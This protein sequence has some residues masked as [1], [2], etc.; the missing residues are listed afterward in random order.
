VTSPRHYGP[1]QLAAFLGLQQ[2]QVERAV[3]AGA[4]PPPDRPRGRWSAVLAGAARARLDE[5]R[6]TAGSVPDLGAVRAAEVLSLR[7]GTVVTADG[8][9]ELG[10][11]GRLP[12]TGDYKGYPLYDGR[13]LESFTDVAAAADATW[14]GHLR[15]ADESASYLRVRRTD[16][17]HLVRAGLL[18]PASYGYGPYDRKG[19]PSVSLYRTG[20]L[21]SL[22]DPGIDWEAVRST[23]AGRRSPLAK[24]PSARRRP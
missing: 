8:V 14:A 21:D 7:L 12:V 16:L 24:L 11:R 22:A 20:D 5:V 1:V 13:E 2:W 9:A 19:R 18:R 3:A 10:R 17:D 23:P 6:A 4:I 15:T